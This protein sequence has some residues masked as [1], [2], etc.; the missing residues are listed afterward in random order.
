MK[1]LI[2]LALAF[3]TFLLFNLSTCPVASATQYSR[4]GIVTAS[5]QLGKWDALKAWIAASGY[6]D[7]WAVCSYLSDDFPQFPAITNAVVASGI[8]T[9]L[10]VAMI[11]AAA[12][13]TALPDALLNARY[14]RDMASQT[15]RT[16]WHGKS[17]SRIDTNACV[18]VWTYEDGYTYT[19]PWTRPKSK[20]EK[21]IEAAQRAA[22]SA[23]AAAKGKPV[24][25][26]ELI[27]ER[28]EAEADSI[29]GRVDTV[30]IDLKE[31]AQ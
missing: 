14:N 18:R 22:S 9:P 1:K 25:I 13:D 29:T 12:R 19:E 20:M 21:K 8:A 27:I 31:G 17:T 30:V 16:G 6:E 28:G 2:Y 5:K 3:S 4:L 26:A 7:E 11:L 10:E 15:G 24:R 23:R